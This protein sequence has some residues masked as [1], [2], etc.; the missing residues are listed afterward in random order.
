[1]LEQEGRTGKRR[2]G[3]HARWSSGAKGKETTVRRSGERAARPPPWRGRGLCPGA[4]APGLP[5]AQAAGAGVGGV[6]SMHTAAAGCGRGAAGWGCAQVQPGN[7][8]ARR[9]A[10]GIAKGPKE[11]GENEVNKGHVQ[12]GAHGGG[13][14]WVKGTIF[15]VAR[16]ARRRPAGASIRLHNKPGQNNPR[17]DQEGWVQAPRAGAAVLRARQGKGQGR[18]YGYKEGG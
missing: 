18:V 7:A 3:G 5:A 10:V 11:D 9:G 14:S 2:G 8:A 12:S 15:A 17:T 16:A 13:G 1:M 4:A 6:A